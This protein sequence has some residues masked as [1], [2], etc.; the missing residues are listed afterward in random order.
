M[1]IELPLETH[2]ALCMQLHP[3]ASRSS[4]ANLDESGGPELVGPVAAVAGLEQLSTLERALRRARYR[5]E[6]TSPEPLLRLTPR[7]RGRS[8]T[9]L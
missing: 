1:E 6:L 8:R 2:H 9:R 4:A 3:G 7:R 5:V